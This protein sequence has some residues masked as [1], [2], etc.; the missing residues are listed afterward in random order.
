VFVVSKTTSS[1]DTGTALPDQLVGVDHRPVPPTL[2]QVTVAAE[3]ELILKKEK[4]AMATKKETKK[5]LNFFW[6]C[7]LAIEGLVNSFCFSG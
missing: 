3:T 5:T 6:K 4:T 1:V 2:V 7:P